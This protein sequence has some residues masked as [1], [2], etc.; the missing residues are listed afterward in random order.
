MAREP[1]IYQ[2]LRRISKTTGWPEAF[3]TDLTNYDRRDLQNVEEGDADAPRVRLIWIL[4]RCGTTLGKCP[5]TLVRIGLKNGDSYAAIQQRVQF[6]ADWVKVNHDEYIV[7]RKEA[8]AKFYRIDVG[9]HQ[10]GTV[11]QITPAEALALMNYDFKTVHG[12]YLEATER[13]A[14]SGTQARKL[15]AIAFT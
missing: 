10:R 7:G 9:Q 12:L 15:K 1:K 2:K 13:P 4:R 11:Q 6:S 3:F 8:G 5:K 14:S